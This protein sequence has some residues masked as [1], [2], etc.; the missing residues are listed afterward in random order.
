MES[1][2]SHWHP[3][4]NQ[5]LASRLCTTQED[6]NIS[7]YLDIVPRNQYASQYVFNTEKFSMSANPEYILST[8]RESG[9][10]FFPID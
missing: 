2:V 5:K 3:A 4:Y 8:G 7:S 1:H 9:P 6:H 10:I